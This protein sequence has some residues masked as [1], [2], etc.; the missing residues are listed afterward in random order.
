MTIKN[1]K[2]GTNDFIYLNAFQTNDCKLTPG[3]VI[4]PANAKD[5]FTT[6]DHKLAG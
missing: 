3:N 1:A 4:E 2:D 5:H 6:N